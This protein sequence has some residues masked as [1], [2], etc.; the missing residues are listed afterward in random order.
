[1]HK[2]TYLYVTNIVYI[3][4]EL[5][6]PAQAAAVVGDV[7]SSEVQNGDE[8]KEQASGATPSGATSPVVVSAE[9][10]NPILKDTPDL[11]E[12]YI[13]P[14]QTLPLVTR[15]WAR[16][17]RRDNKVLKTYY[18]VLDRGTLSMFKDSREEPPYGHGMKG[19]LFLSSFRASKSTE[20]NEDCVVVLTFENSNNQEP[21]VEQVTTTTTASDQPFTPRNVSSDNVTSVDTSRNSLFDGIRPVVILFVDQKSRDKWL[22]AFRQHISWA[23]LHPE[24]DKT[25]SSESKSRLSWI[26]SPFGKK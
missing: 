22:V 9:T 11:S 25:K 13:I 26:P 7:N 14:N 21:V 24:D 3:S 4:I 6:D 16:S 10:I 15:T 17:K 8:S 23:V 19:S 5:K 20:S 18:F 12:A 2:N 1:M